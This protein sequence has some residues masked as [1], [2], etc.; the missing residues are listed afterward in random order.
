M[1]CKL[2]KQNFKNAKS[3]TAHLISHKL[4]SKEYFDKFLSTPQNNNICPVCR[5]LKTKYRN[6]TTGY[7]Q[8]CSITCSNLYEPIIQIKKEINKGRKQ[9]EET[10]QKRIKNTNQQKKEKNRRLTCLNKYGYEY[11]SQL[12]NIKENLSKIHKNSKKPRGKEH[13]QKIINSKIK[14]NTIKHT[15]ETK[16]KISKILIENYQKHDPPV[17]LSYSYNSKRKYQIGKIYGLYY[18]SSYEKQFIITCYNNNI[19]INIISA[20]SKEFR[21]PNIYNGKRKFYYPDFYLPNYNIIIEIKPTSLLLDEQTISKINAALKY[22]ENFTILTEEDLFDINL[23]WVKEL[24][25]FLFAS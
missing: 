7:P 3:L 23:Q 16:N 6:I 20:E 15:Q 14:N 8:T 17:T 21:V 11:I 13:Q 4:T 18:R 22:H 12:P 10:I 5:K 24:E 9:T 19:N 2:C 25:Y 1:E